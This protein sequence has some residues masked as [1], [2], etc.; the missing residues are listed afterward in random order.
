MEMGGVMKKLH[1]H[2]SEIE[3]TAWVLIAI[4]IAALL[5]F[6][7]LFWNRIS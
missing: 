5:M 3:A 2:L 1:Q 4:F 6:T 7:Y